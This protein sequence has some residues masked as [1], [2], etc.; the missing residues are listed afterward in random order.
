MMLTT[1]DLLDVPTTY[2]KVKS[3]IRYVDVIRRVFLTPAQLFS[4]RINPSRNDSQL[5]RM[6]TAN[7]KAQG[8]N[9]MSYPKFIPR[10][11]QK[12]ICIKCPSSL[13]FR[14]SEWCWRHLAGQLQRSTNAGH[15]EQ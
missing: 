13:M 8:S 7:S 10:G 14:R 2:H 12:C 6:D 15:A 11:R 9:H 3:F 1:K 5:Y 4:I